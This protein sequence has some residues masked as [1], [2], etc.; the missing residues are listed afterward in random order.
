MTYSILSFIA[1]TYTIAST[2][3][4]DSPLKPLALFN[5]ILCLLAS[6]VIPPMLCDKP[7]RA[8]NEKEQADADCNGA[9]RVVKMIQ[10]LSGHIIGRGHRQGQQ[11]QLS[12]EDAPA[13]VVFDGALQEHCGIDP[14]RAASHV[15][16]HQNDER[17]RKVRRASEGHIEK[18][19][20]EKRDAD[21][22]LHR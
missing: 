17:E 5:R 19:A 13:K 14:E 6:L 10:Q 4:L 9:R 2:P 20:N 16:N 15:R 22:F 18:S 1:C 7:E 21:C 12:R 8:G 11:R 3:L